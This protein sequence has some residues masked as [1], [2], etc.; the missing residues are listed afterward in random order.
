MKLQVN[1]L[2]ISYEM[3]L[4]SRQFIVVL[5]KMSCDQTSFGHSDTPV[6]SHVT[7]L[8]ELLA[9]SRHLKNVVRCPPGRMT[10]WSEHPQSITECGGFDLLTI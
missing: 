2:K 5:T 10:F 6:H 7:S 1:A 4:F 9:I 8:M 3:T